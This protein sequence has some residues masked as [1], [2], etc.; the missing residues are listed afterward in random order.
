MAFLNIFNQPFFS[1]GDLILQSKTENICEIEIFY[2]TDQQFPR[3]RRLKKLM[4]SS[5]KI[6]LFSFYKKFLDF[7]S[8]LNKIVSAMD[9]EDRPNL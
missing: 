7:Y 8:H 2:K 4:A 5:K 1:I 6:I 9:G 3:C